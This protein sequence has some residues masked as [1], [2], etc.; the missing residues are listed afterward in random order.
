MIRLLMAGLL[1]SV[2]SFGW[3]S[4]YP[5][6]YEGV[7]N[8]FKDGDIIKAEDFN[9]NNVSIKK[10]INN[11]ASGETGP[12]GPA[13][14]KGD[15][16]ATGPAGATGSVGATGPAGP[17]GDTGGTA[18]GDI[19]LTSTAGDV[20]IDAAAGKDVKIAGGQVTLSSKDYEASAAL[21]ASGIS[22]RTNFG[23][24]ELIKVTN[25]QGDSDAAIA[26]T[27][28]GGGINLSG[29]SLKLNPGRG[30]LITK[31]SVQTILDSMTDP[32]AVQYIAG[33]INVTGGDADSFQLPTGA[34]LAD[35]MPGSEVSVGDSFICYVVNAS[36]GVI[37]YSQG[38]AGSTLTGSEGS[39]LTQKNNSLAKIDF[40][41]TVATDGSEQYHALL[42]ADH[43]E[44][45]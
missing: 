25:S 20:D 23:T 15:T 10:A 31:R 41:F 6:K 5:D 18:E 28:T 11:I 22:L 38:A 17:K 42:V 2:S 7:P 27:A 35:K 13:G 39:N 44:L 30:G 40:I 24:H 8:T 21:G 19:A 32:T 26:L 16:G 1:L 34:D 12:Q 9:N 14:P 3:A 45:D 36:G 33:F 37:T 29:Q 4:A 43:L